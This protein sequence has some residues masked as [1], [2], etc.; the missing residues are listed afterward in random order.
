MH[1]IKNPTSRMWKWKLKLSNFQFDI[2]YKVGRVN[3]NADA[4]SRNAPELC[5]PIRKREEEEGSLAPLL[6]R[7]RLNTLTEDSPIFEAKP[8]GLPQFCDPGKQG[9]AFTQEHLAIEET[10]AKILIRHGKIS[11]I[12]L[13]RKHPIWKQT[14]SKR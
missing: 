9:K 2:R 11:M 3:G 8:R 6:K 14:I 10:P 4:L 13:T 12:T 1:Y 5:L 7:F